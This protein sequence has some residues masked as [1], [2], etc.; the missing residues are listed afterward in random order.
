MEPENQLEWYPRKT[1]YGV[2]PPPPAARDPDHPS[3][4]DPSPPPVVPASAYLKYP[5]F[6]WL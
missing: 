4:L 3:A 1:L 6:G 2:D 5:S